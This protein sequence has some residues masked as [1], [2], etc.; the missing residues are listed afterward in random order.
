MKRRIERKSFRRRIAVGFF[1]CFVLVSIF[2]DIRP[3]YAQDSRQKQEDKYTI[4]ANIGYKDNQVRFYRNSLLHV[5]VGNS[6]EQEFRGQVCATMAIGEA[7]LERRYEKEVII[8]AGE[9]KELD[10]IVYVDIEPKNVQVELQ[11]ADGVR[12][13]QCQSELQAISSSSFTYG[14]LTKEGELLKYFRQSGEKQIDFTTESLPDVAEG[15]DALDLLIIDD[16]DDE[17]LSE[18]QVAAVEEWVRTGGTL[19]L[20]VTP[21][22]GKKMASAF[23]I[24]VHSDKKGVKVTTAQAEKTS[25]KKAGLNLYRVERGQGAVVISD[26]CLGLEKKRWEPLG[27]YYLEAVESQYGETA[28]LLQFADYNA[29][30]VYSFFDFSGQ[31]KQL[32][33][34]G[35]IVL[36]FAVY[37]LFISLGLR[38]LLGTKDKQHLIWIAVPVCSVFFVGIMYGMGSKSR[39]SDEQIGYQAMV[40]YSENDKLAVGS[41]YI[42]VLAADNGELSMQFPEAVGVYASS[43]WENS[44]KNYEGMGGDAITVYDDQVEDHI[45]YG[46]NEQGKTITF[47]DISALSTQQFQVDYFVE[48]KGDY[49]T[50]LTCKDYEL[51]GTITNHMGATMKHAFLVAD[52]KVYDLGN[53]EDGQ[54][55]KVDSGT[56]SYFLRNLYLSNIMGEQMEKLLSFGKKSQNENQFMWSCF[57]EGSVT[58]HLITPRLYCILD[59]DNTVMEQLLP[60]GNGTTIS[61]FSVNVD[62][63][64]GGETFVSSLFE[65]DTELEGVYN[66]CLYEYDNIVEAHLPM[67]QELTGL[68]YYAETDVTQKKN[69]DYDGEPEL[70]FDGEVELYNFR[71]KEYD[72]IF[73]GGDKDWSTRDVADYVSEDNLIRMHVVTD[74]EAL[75]TRGMNC[76]I[77]SATM[78]E[79]K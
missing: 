36:L 42:S 51:S 34:M 53:I 9:E 63:K 25:Y 33:A 3:A 61:S 26:Q 21:S 28:R 57:S 46:Q 45:I 30:P 64:H 8:P 73:K 44:W 19:L 24:A 11:N 47:S 55:I 2:A 50:D 75:D 49:Q 52:R 60:Q 69:E 5:V 71:T 67:N 62:Y 16:M 20:A 74:N 68:Y 15:L 78:K 14:T 4:S 29:T 40:R 13:A 31:L 70:A 22:E 77:I 79:V 6:T 48:R 59:T 12:V 27:R 38:F 39:V 17:L 43:G 10:F 37:V 66:Q 76:P 35:S 7:K 32:P 18:E 58:E 41:G 72:T 54:T 23:G 1:L 65:E 56:T